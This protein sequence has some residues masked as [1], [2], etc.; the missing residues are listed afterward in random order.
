MEKIGEGKT[1]IIYSDGK[2]AY[3]KFKASYKGNEQYE[4]RVQNEVFNHTKLPVLKYELENDMLKMPFING[5]EFAERM[6]VER[7]RAWL[8]DFID[9]QTSIYQYKD[10]NLPDSF[11]VYKNQIEET[12]IDD[13]LK[14]NAL[15]ALVR[16]P[17]MQSLC[18]FDF[19]P[20]NIMYEDDIYY[21][22]D[23]TNAKLSNP[24]MDIASTYIIFRLY[25]KRQANKYLREII[26]KT[27]FNRN[28]I[29]EALPV[30]AFI[31]LR[32]NDI[33]DH[34]ILLKNLILRKDKIFE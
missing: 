31:K 32:E 8:V 30:I 5:V 19:H 27:G 22:M 2:F 4:M 18:H 33:P 34:E 10:L 13:T 29:I 11:K 6:L 15:D 14:K 1:A 3:K 26:K 17:Y 7:Y 21:I 16:V 12:D 20:L 25:I 23:W 28:D 9:L 24:V